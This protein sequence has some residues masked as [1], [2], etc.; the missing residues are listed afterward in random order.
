MKEH[1]VNV[2]GVAV[3]LAPGCRIGAHLERCGE[4]EPE[5]LIAW[6]DAVQPGK[7]VIDVGAY[8]GLYAILAAKLG[9]FAVALEP[10]NDQRGQLRKN[11]DLNDVR[12]DVQIRPIAASDRAG[13][14]RLWFNGRVSLTSGASVDKDAGSESVVVLSDAIDNLGYG[15]VCAIKIDAERH[16]PDVLRGAA[17]TIARDRPVLIVESLDEASREA[18]LREVPGYEVARVLDGRNLLLLPRGG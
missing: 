11:V 14:L 16:E 12:L 6:A 15:D 4:F 10:M 1:I 5:S 13:S 17:K 7:A 18:I 8:T 3:A 2:G 9:G